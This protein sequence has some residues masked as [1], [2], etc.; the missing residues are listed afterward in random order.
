M[1]ETDV[2]MVVLE[3]VARQ[4]KGS[5]PTAKWRGLWREAIAP[6][7][8][9]EVRAWCR[10][11]ASAE[12][13]ETVATSALWG[14]A[15]VAVRGTPT[16]IADM[17]WRLFKDGHLK[18]A[19]AA[20]TGIGLIAEEA[21]TPELANEAIN[22]LQRLKARIKHRTVAK[23]ANQALSAVAEARQLS[24][25]ALQD[26][27]VESGG[28]SLDGSRKWEAG[29]H[30][31]YLF[32]SD[33]GEIELGIFERQSG[34]ALGSAPKAVRHEHFAVLSEVKAVQKALAEALT[35]QKQRLE[36]A[37]ESERTWPAS[38]WR[39]VFGDHPL[40]RH[41]ARRLV[42]RVGE[43]E[44]AY[45][46]AGFQTVEGAPFVPAEDA[47][48]QL[49]HPARLTPEVV[50]AWQ[51]HV[52]TRRLVQPFKQVFR[53]VF[54]PTAEDLAIGRYSD[55]FAGQVVRHRQMYALLRGRQWSGLGGVGPTGYQGTKDLQGHDL[56]AVVGFRQFR[57]Y[58][59]VQRR[60]VT[61]EQVEFY[62]LPM[63]AWTPGTDLRVPIA[64]IP[65]VAYSE[66][67][68]DVALVVG[69]AGQGTESGLRGETDKALPLPDALSGIAEMRQ[70]LLM[71]LLPSLG[72]GE[73]IR[74]G[75]TYAE[76]DARGQVFRL[77]LLTG[78]VTLPRD[79]DRRLD[80]EGIERSDSPLYLPH[81]G[82][83]TATAAILATLLW[84]AQFG[85][86]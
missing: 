57:H 85:R 79:G 14:L 27:V 28:L 31:L 9:E 69:V 62:P 5:R 11:H 20:I 17:A 19:T 67:M 77:S 21:E 84:L 16:Q 80:L 83:D 59:D 74:V 86:A 60:Q 32:L 42:W 8:P 63:P 76:I 35:V 82:A 18:L 41:L 3:G 68:R 54:R 30:D 29:A 44:V 64:E 56:K 71:E 53:E 15:A 48:V 7:T 45:D 50:R 2:R 36:S 51:R 70:A 37:L 24:A 1:G 61:L 55:R 65:P 58:Q 22:Q 72:F 81:E 52:V 47:T 12:V 33:D 23:R 40:M 49:M 39:Q 10:M 13:D 25:E 6:F 38:L 26:L 34:R 75:D 73:R 4:A 46:G 78:E 66:V 43:Q